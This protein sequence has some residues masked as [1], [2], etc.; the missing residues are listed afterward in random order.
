MLIV[1]NF[2]VVTVIALFLSLYLVFGHA[3]YEK[4][5]LEAQKIFYFQNLLLLF[6]RTQNAIVISS[7]KR[8]SIVVLLRLVIKVSVH[9]LL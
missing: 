7:Y 9:S 1:K 8:M 2:H 4:T 6:L 5:M 3:D